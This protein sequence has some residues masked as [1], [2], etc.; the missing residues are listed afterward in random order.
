MHTQHNQGNLFYLASFRGK[1]VWT[2]S[3]VLKH[4]NLLDFKY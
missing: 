4:F 2:A 1:W 3:T